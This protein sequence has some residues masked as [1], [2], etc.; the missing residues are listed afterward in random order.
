MG[1]APAVDAG[2]A[3]YSDAPM[4][5]ISLMAR[6]NAWV[7]Q[8][9]YDAVAPLP[10][11]ARTADDG[12]FFGSV[13]H[14]LNHVLLVDRMWLARIEGVP[15]GF[16]SLDQ[17]L[18]EDFDSLRAARVDEDARFV[19]VAD[20]MDAAAQARVVRY[21]RMIGSGEE[22]VRAG[23]I[24]LTL[25]N[26]QTHHRGQVTAALHRHGVKYPPLDL[27]FFLDEIGEAGP[28]GTLDWAPGAPPP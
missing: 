23:H 17:V 24:M 16:A 13:H 9:V 18:Y 28:P 26:H 1:L 15:H 7:N 4:D 21:T 27:V 20:G 5:H 11:A 10:P 2:A 3:I 6:F 14:T 8:R 22:N 19:R 12:L 25:L